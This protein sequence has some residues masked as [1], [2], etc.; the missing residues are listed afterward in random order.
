MR[1]KDAGAKPF[2]MLTI[3]LVV[4]GMLLAASSALTQDNPVMLGLA[5]A[6]ELIEEERGAPLRLLRWRYYEDNWSSE[7]SWRL[8]RSFG[9]DSCVAAVP[10]LLKRA[11]IL[12][13]WT[14]SLLD[15]SGK[16]YQARVSYD[17]AESVLCD[18][19]HVPPQFAPAPAPQPAPAAPEAAQEAAASETVA[20][21][22]IAST[23]NIGGF[24]LGGHIAG[25]G[26]GAVNAMRQA[27]MTWVKKQVTHGISDGA[28]IIA[29]ARAQGFKVLLGALGSKDRL[30]DNFDG[31]I[32]EFAQYVGFLASQGADAIEVWNEPNIDREW[33]LGQVNGGRY[34]QLLAAAYN[35]IKAANPN[36]IVISGAPAPTG[37]FGA[38]G[39]TANGCNDDVFMQQMAQAGGAQYMDCLGLHYNEGVLSPTQSGGDPRG[40][41]PT[42]FFHSMLNRG[43]QYFPNTKVCWTELGY[44]SGEGMPGPIPAHFAWASN[45]TV[46]QQ[47]QWLADAA[48]L[49]RNSGR[50]RLMIVWN[51]DFTHWGADPQAGY[52]IIRPGGGC[53]ACDTLR[54]AMGG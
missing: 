44:L 8:Y 14:F 25:F 33:P 5:V 43:L 12:F 53:P 52:A 18:E 29:A 17:L 35:A 11:D 40:H 32:A 31:Y 20:V 19:V 9:I 28:G 39:C 21:A 41:Y 2:R 49:S 27:G 36:T 42:Y 47:A 34:V 7:A 23:A 48:R 37:Y 6:R 15:A 38:A 1:L 22:P 16:E 46:P 4:L 45:V 30:R 26:G 13:G 50:V 51:V 10:P 54:A 3:L 24:E